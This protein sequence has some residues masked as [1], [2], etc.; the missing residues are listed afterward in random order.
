MAK[1]ADSLGGVCAPLPPPEA[2]KGGGGSSN[3]AEDT[4]L[5]R[6]TPGGRS[7]SRPDP[8]SKDSYDV[9]RECP[10]EP[11]A[12]L[13]RPPTATPATRPPGTLV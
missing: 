5:W 4:L 12:E 7:A 11:R 8:T 6:L 3:A 2:M 9:W 1:P 13:R 10:R